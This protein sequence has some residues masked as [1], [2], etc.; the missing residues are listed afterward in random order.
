MTL[1]EG[2]INGVK[3]LVIDDKVVIFMVH[4]LLYLHMEQHIQVMTAVFQ[5]QYKSRLSTDR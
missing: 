4:A 2:E 1:C 5:I 3:E